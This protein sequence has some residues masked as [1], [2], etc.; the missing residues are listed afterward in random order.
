[1]SL[2]KSFLNLKKLHSK[3]KIRVLFPV[4][5]VRIKLKVILKGKLTNIKQKMKLMGLWLNSPKLQKLKK[6]PKKRKRS[7]NSKSL[8]LSIKRQHWKSLIS[9]CLKLRYKKTKTLYQIWTCHQLVNLCTKCSL[10]RHKF[11]RW[12]LRLLKALK[13]RQGSNTL[14]INWKS[15][16]MKQQK[17]KKSWQTTKFLL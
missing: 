14:I 13:Q 16:R 10:P 1:M 12:T 2:S 11:M 17:K 9:P 3:I 5:R 4:S 6:N 15:K 7:S 8:N